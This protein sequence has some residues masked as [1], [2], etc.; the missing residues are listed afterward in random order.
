MLGRAAWG[1]GAPAGGV[2]AFKAAY[3]SPEERDGLEEAQLAV[4]QIVLPLRQPVELL[5]RTEAVRAA[6]AAMAE[7]YRLGVEVVG[8]GGDA[9]LRIL[10]AAAAGAAAGEGEAA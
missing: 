3:S 10:P 7:R 1:G 2:S 4:E 5:P 9:R 8:E 6:Q